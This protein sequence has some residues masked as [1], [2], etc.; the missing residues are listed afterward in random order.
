M[1]T[2]DQRRDSAIYF[3]A[4]V[5]A[6][7]LIFGG[8][9]TTLP[10]NPADMTADQIKEAVKDKSASVGCVTIQTPYKGNSVFL[11][12]DKGVLAVGEITISADCIVTIKN[13]PTPPKP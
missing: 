2:L 4:L 7:A 12:L 1:T 3:L 6:A 13:A 5:I 8:C 10:M 11:N 9:A